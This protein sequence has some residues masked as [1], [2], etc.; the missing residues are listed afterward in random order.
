MIDVRDVGAIG[1]SL[2]ISS[3]EFNCCMDLDYHDIVF[4]LL[5]IY[6]MVKR[7]YTGQNVVHSCR[8]GG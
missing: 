8:L 6:T 5:L 1:P 4:L 3:I 7:N 2:S